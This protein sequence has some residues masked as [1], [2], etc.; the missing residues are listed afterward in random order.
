MK[1]SLY[2]LLA[3]DY[4]LEE[5]VKY[6]A[7]A[8]FDA[9]DIRQAEDGAH[10]PNG[11]PPSDG[12][13]CRQLVAD[14]G[15][16]I[17]GLTTYYRLGCTDFAETAANLN[18]IE[19]S[20]DL[21]I[22]MGA[23]YFRISGPAYDAEAGYERQRQ[24]TREQAVTIGEMAKAR[25]LIVTV[26]QHGGALTASAGQILDLFRGLIHDNF[27]VV[28]DPGN[29]LREG[30]ERPS[31][32]IDML[33]DAM[34]AVHV[35]NAMTHSGTAVDEMLPVE[36]IRLD[37]GILN[38]PDIIAAIEATGYDGYY[39]LEDFSAFETI[40]EKFKWNVEYLRQIASRR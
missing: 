2:T 7:D 35:K 14:Y 9:V 34:K 38:W 24:L 25:D 18:G 28:Y 6:A 31:V 20:M 27:G 40:P 15:L 10:L 39:M 1:L 5:A 3:K 36:Q 29:C 8:G 37:K 23:K 33:R 19:S 13:R 4:T 26:E 17:S 21:A 11:A 30:Y 22:A 32:Q 12:N 16:H